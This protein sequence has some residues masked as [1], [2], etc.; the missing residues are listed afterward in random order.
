[1][2]V[3]IV[4]DD[5]FMRS[6][7]VATVS[8]LGHVVVGDCASGAD[9]MHAAKAERPDVALLDLDLGS[10]PTGADIG[11]ALRRDYP[12]LGIVMLTSYEEPRLM[13]TRLRIPDRAVYLVK[14]SVSRPQE[15]DRALRLAREPRAHT[16]ASESA[17]VISR[18]RALSDGQIEIMRLVASGLTNAE[19][20]KRRY[21]SEHAVGKAVA[22]LVTQLKLD[23]GDGENP[24]VLITQAYFAMT[25]AARP[26]RD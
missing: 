7:L 3:L 16:S 13:G 19:I 18:A 4:E 12:A 15:I 11:Q 1:V 20:G 9:A 25:G 21:M 10:G 14:Q 24:R 23:Y 6:L 26:H 17:Q 8:G 22:R 5:N 2:R